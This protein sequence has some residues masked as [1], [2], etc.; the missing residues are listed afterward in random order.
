MRAIR[1][2]VLLVLALALFAYTTMSRHKHWQAAQIHQ[3][4]QK[5]IK[6][7][8]APHAIPPLVILKSKES[9]A[10]VTKKQLVITTGMLE[11]LENDSQVAAILGHEIGHVMLG[12]LVF[13]FVEPRVKEVNS[14]KYGAYL[15]LRSGY[16]TCAMKKAWQN[17]QESEGNGILTVSHPSHA[18]RIHS[19][20]FPH[21]S[22]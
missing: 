10:W 8:G 17:I 11:L 19:A 9:N 5:L 20:D 14:D 4:Y 21:C 13:S 16:N 2:S 12:H 1:L 7:T 18:D 22:W 3:I 6:H 15:M